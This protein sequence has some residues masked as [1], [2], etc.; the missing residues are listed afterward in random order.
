MESTIPW[1]LLDNLHR[2]VQYVYFAVSLIVVFGWQSCNVT[3]V[4]SGTYKNVQ[5]N[6]QNHE[7]DSY[8]TDEVFWVVEA[9][10]EDTTMKLVTKIS[11][12]APVTSDEEFQLE[13]LCEDYKISQRRPEVPVV[14]DNKIRC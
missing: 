7:A 10:Y 9:K 12:A 14:I 8:F 5:S 2:I 1:L 11:E 3:L 13:Q 4:T 6:K